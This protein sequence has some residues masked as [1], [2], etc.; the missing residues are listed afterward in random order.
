MGTI[1]ANKCGGLALMLAPVITLILYFLQ[2]G[3][4]LI[5]AAD[6][7]DGAATIAAMVGNPGLGKITSVL[8]PLG[9]IAMSYGIYVLQAN[10]R[11]SGNGDALSRL[12]AIF[13]LVAAAGWMVASGAS[14]AIYGSTFSAQDSYQAYGSLYGATVGIGTIAGLAGGIGFLALALA[15]STRE[16]SNK[17]AALVVAVASIVSIV[18]IIIGAVDTTLLQTMTLITGITYIVTVIWFFMVG[19]NLAKA[20]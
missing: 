19:Q 18:V 14:L 10:I 6:P 13:F 7:A 8:I 2:P 3:G 17:I 5:D 9:L 15:I 4:A 20:K 11:A 1:S 12:G 16:D